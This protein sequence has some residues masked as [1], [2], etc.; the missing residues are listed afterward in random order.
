MLS[1]SVIYVVGLIATMKKAMDISYQIIHQSTASNLIP[2]V[3][4]S[5]FGQRTDSRR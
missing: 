2:M 3:R 1:D 4:E 5:V